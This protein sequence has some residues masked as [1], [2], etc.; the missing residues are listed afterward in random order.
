[1]NKPDYKFMHVILNQSLRL[2]GGKAMFSVFLFTLIQFFVMGIAAFPVRSGGSVNAIF[3][4]LILL[5]VMNVCSEVFLYGLYI[6]IARLIEKKFVTIGFLFIG[7]RRNRKKI[8]KAGVLFTLIYV[9]ITVIISALLFAYRD[10]VHGLIEKIGMTH[11]VL[12]AGFFVLLL[13][14]L[15]TIPFS[16]VRLI[17]YEYADM[18]VL[19]AFKKSASLLKGHFF[20][21]IGFILYAS[22]YHLA[23]MI[24]IQVFLMFVPSDGELSPSMQL[25]TTFLSIAGIIAQYKALTR[26][27]MAVT[28]YYYSIKGVIHPHKTE[29][30]EK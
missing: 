24:L 6:I 20:N 14:I 16:F 28:I 3:F 8:I 15:I 30:I 4:S 17:L 13:A 12:I 11:A 10:A 26:Y 2:N 27:F 23:Q 19:N 7:F 18:G 21:F 9:V 29:D 1:M 5:F 25:V 22:G